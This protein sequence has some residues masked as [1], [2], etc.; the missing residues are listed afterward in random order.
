[1]SGHIFLDDESDRKSWQNPEEI[2]RAAGLRQ[3]QTFMDIGCG[4]GFFTIPAARI[5]GSEGKAYGL[6][7]NDEAIRMLG[8]RAERE[9]LNI[10]L[11][12][13]WAEE[14][15]FCE[16]CADVVFFG[17]VLHDFV[18]VGRV[19]VNAYSMLKPGGALVDVDWKK[20]PMAPGPPLR[21]RFSE[22]DAARRIERAG[23][24]IE[25]VE[26]SGPYNYVIVA[27]KLAVGAG[28]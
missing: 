16:A 17:I 11:R 28:N 21:R 25:S 7:I 22:E 15:V 18:D 20:E 5:V 24:R 23:F 1:M 27:R 8:R 10:V 9:G 3:G 12:V 2:L 6:D 19:L 26:D 14:V 4:T 13:G